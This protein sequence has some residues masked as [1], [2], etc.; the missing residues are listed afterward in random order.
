MSFSIQYR[1]SAY[2]HHVLTGFLGADAGLYWFLSDVLH[3]LGYKNGIGKSISNV[4]VQNIAGPLTRTLPHVYQRKRVVSHE[5]MLR[6]F[7][8]SRMESVQEF[9]K[10]LDSPETYVKC[11]VKHDVTDFQNP[12]QLVILNQVTV[13]DMLRYDLF[14]VW[15]TFFKKEVSEKLYPDKFVEGFLEESETILK[16]PTSSV[17]KETVVVQET[18]V[19]PN[20]GE[21]TAEYLKNIVLEINGKTKKFKLVED[22]E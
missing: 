15:Y 21:E 22:T 19:V 9:G 10:K 17:A 3:I 20:E 14:Y 1:P 16:D 2:H 11:L 8:L 18:V 12:T 7:Q 4:R 13:T 6:Y 5:A